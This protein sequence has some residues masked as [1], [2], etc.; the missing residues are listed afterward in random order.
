MSE[1]SESER[2][3]PCDAGCDW[4]SPWTDHED[5]KENPNIELAANTFN[6]GTEVRIYE[7]FD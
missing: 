4:V 6:V 5:Y 1:R 2:K 7:P 3:L